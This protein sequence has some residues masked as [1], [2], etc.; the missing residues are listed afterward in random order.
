[1]KH[2]VIQCS[3][4]AEQMDFKEFEAQITLRLLSDTECGCSE[5]C[6]SIHLNLGTLKGLFCN[7]CAALMIV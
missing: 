1:M 7:T 3:R 2:W 6:S 4:Q 5:T